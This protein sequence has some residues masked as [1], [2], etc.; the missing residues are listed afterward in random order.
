MIKVLEGLGIDNKGDF[1]Q[2]LKNRQPEQRELKALPLKSGT[3]Q[4]Y[5]LI[6]YSV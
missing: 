3:I 4:G 6:Q 1:Q 2:T 5:I